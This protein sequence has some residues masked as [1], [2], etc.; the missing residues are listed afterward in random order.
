MTKEEKLVIKRLHKIQD[1]K[2]FV[3]YEEYNEVVPMEILSGDEAEEWLEIAK[4]EGIHLLTAKETAEQ[5][6][7]VEIAAK[8]ADKEKK[9]KKTAKKASKQ[10][11]ESDKD[12]KTKTVKK[13]KAS[14]K[15][16][17]SLDAMPMTSDSELTNAEP[18][19]P[20]KT[21]K[22]AT[23]A[24]KKEDVASEKKAAS[25][26]TNK[27]KAKASEKSTNADNGATEKS[28]SAPKTT[29][30]TAKDKAKTETVDSKADAESKSSD[31]LNK[32]K[33]EV[34]TQEEP[35]KAAKKSSTKS[36]AEGGKTEEKNKKNVKAESNDDKNVVKK[37]EKKSDKVGKSQKNSSLTKSSDEN[38]EIDEK[39]SKTK[40]AKEKSGKA[41]KAESAKESKKKPVDSGVEK[42][43][44]P[45]VSPNAVMEKS[46]KNASKPKMGAPLPSQMAPAPHII[47]KPPQPVKNDIETLGTGVE[48]LD[49]IF[50]GPGKPASKSENFPEDIDP[51]DVDPTDI[52]EDFENDIID[53]EFDSGDV[54]DS[55]VEV[56][57]A[58]FDDEVDP[59]GDDL[60]LYDDGEAEHEESDGDADMYEASDE[61][62]A[63]DA[64][65]DAGLDSAQDQDYDGTKDRDKSSDP[66]RSYLQSMIK[67]SLLS[68][69]GEVEIAKRVEEGEQNVLN[70]L[71]QSSFGVREIIAIAESVRRDKLKMRDVLRDFEMDYSDRTD[72]EI[73]QEFLDHVDVIREI[74]RNVIRLRERLETAHGLSDLYV[75]RIRCCLER[76]RRSLYSL[77]LQIRLSKKLS[78]RLVYKLKMMIE[79]LNTASQ[80]IKR[81]E[82]ESGVSA[83]DI[84]NI[85]K[86]IQANP[87]DTQTILS[88]KRF[89]ETK[90]FSYFDTITKYERDVDSIERDTHISSDALRLTYQRVQ[91]GQRI[92]EIAKSELIEA[93][94]RLVVSIAKK[95]TNRGLQFLDLIQE[96]NIGLMKAVD[97]FEYKR[98]YKF[99]TYATWWIRQAITRAIADQARTI[100][101]PVHMIETINKLIRTSRCLVQD[102]GR[103]PTPEEIAEKMELPVEKVRK[104]LK[105][106]KE[107]ISLE[108]PIGEEEDSH[109]GDFIEDK[110]VV[111]PADAVISMNLSEQ[112]RK[113]LATLTP[114][115]EKVLRMRFGIGE[116]SDHTL[117][118]VGQDF[119]VTRER[120]R[121]IE[122]KALRKLRHPTRSKQLKPFVEN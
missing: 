27:S 55:G 72:D 110:S 68:R 91:K 19:K 121:Q 17:A 41:T 36:S 87:K 42:S 52:D 96:G 90:V 58:T 40:K 31:T 29:K 50:G 71:L 54:S 26:K 67:V 84:L 102:L 94:L 108:T 63:E 118:E 59:I 78:E 112:T 4:K 104:V 22:K 105:I 113:V 79:R 30:K 89:N 51:A 14:K 107:P 21:V 43:A 34:S 47:H 64:D 81:C 9:V 111:S 76:N 16:E 100:R 114:R 61:E 7:H 73:K 5:G 15:N 65:G 82:R 45:D 49:V 48:P 13:V 6:L 18:I 23:K 24:A 20:E 120:I 3:T 66:V 12:E 93:N 60:D 32:G 53:D 70:V 25:V 119:E 37:T 117:E 83:R 44:K 85:C 28:V 39:A 99:S 38:T 116:K 101:I 88:G 122:A 77:M 92:A 1:A 8:D 86:E 106:G 98:G 103:E 33:N 74:N 109:L 57:N 11:S 35:K 2:G 75:E 10:D 80:E 115:E 56:G 62:G 95:Y 69:D 46:E 97:K